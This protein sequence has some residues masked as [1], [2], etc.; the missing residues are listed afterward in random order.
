MHVLGDPSLPVTFFTTSQLLQRCLNV[1]PLSRFA[2]LPLYIIIYSE[3]GPHSSLGRNHI[4]LDQPLHKSFSSFP[5]YILTLR[6][7]CIPT[8]PSFSLLNVYN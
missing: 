5:F 7:S 1:E 8:V 6:D 4:N 3:Y 2:P